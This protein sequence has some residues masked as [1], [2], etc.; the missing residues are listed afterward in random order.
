M[1]SV[2]RLIRF[3]L[4]AGVVL[5]GVAGFFLL[6]VEEADV[7][8]SG[9]GERIWPVQVHAV[10]KETITPTIELFGEVV[11]SG[12]AKIS[13]IV[14]AQV[15]A[16]HVRPGDYV[17]QGDPLVEFNPRNIRTRVAQLEA[18]KARVQAEIDHEIERRETDRKLL[19]HELRLLDLSKRI[20]S[21]IENLKGRILDTQ[22]RY[23]R[24]QSD[25]QSN[26]LAVT[27]RRAAIRGFDAR[28]QRMQ[29]DLARIQSSLDNA[30]RDYS[31]SVIAAPFTGRISSVHVAVGNRVSNGT[32]VVE[33]FDHT[34]VEVETLIP[35]QYMPRFRDSPSQLPAV[36]EVDGEKVYLEFDRLAGKV[37]TA[38]GGGVGAFIRV[39]DANR[40]PEL[41]RTLTVELSLHPVEQAI[42]IPFQSVYGVDRVFKVEGDR[43]RSVK[44]ERHGQMNSEGEMRIVARSSEIADGDLLVITPLTNAAD[45]LKVEPE[46]IG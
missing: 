13:S 28:V 43:L 46:P 25:V 24:A 40:F 38:S 12:V 14:S 3:A 29:A 7:G 35:S 11:T 8:R 6:D 33:M 45:G 36:A 15:L 44:I 5:A 16:V 34:A 31:E 32:A 39:V 2:S 42:A 21:R 17:S 19:L 26:D 22:S 1:D 23:E 4:P 20:M 9:A 10:K 27:V 37:E 18:D 41:G 30:R